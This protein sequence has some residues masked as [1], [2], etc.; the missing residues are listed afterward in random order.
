MKMALIETM[1]DELI[2]ERYVTTALTR[3]A[4]HWDTIEITEE[5]YHKYEELRIALDDYTQE[6]RRNK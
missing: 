1:K 5:Q 2:Q 6:L 4:I 3:K